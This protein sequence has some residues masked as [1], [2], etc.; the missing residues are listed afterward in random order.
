MDIKNFTEYY[1]TKLETELMV[2]DKKR[3]LIMP[4][5]I[6]LRALLSFFF[7]F[8]L[9]IFTAVVVRLRPDNSD[10]FIVNVLRVFFSILIIG[11]FTLFTVF[12][13]K[14]LIKT[15]PKTFSTKTGE[16][17]LGFGVFFFL[18]GIDF[19]CAFIFTSKVRSM[20]DLNIGGIILY[21][22]V[23]LVGGGFLFYFLFKIEQKFKVEFKK[24]IMAKLIEF[25]LPGSGY[26]PEEAIESN[27]FFES[28]LFP[29]P[30]NLVYKGSDYLKI[31]K[32]GVKMSLS[33]LDVSSRSRG[34]STS[35]SSGNNSTTIFSGI[36]F[37]ILSEKNYFG[38]TRVFFYSKAVIALQK[39][40]SAISGMG[41]G[42]N[43]QRIKTGNAAFDK[44]FLVYSNYPEGTLQCLTSEKMKNILDFYE[45]TK[46]KFSVSFINNIVYVATSKQRNIF[47]PPIFSS[48]TSIKKMQNYCNSIE[49]IYFY[50]HL[51]K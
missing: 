24:K 16:V 36:F 27:I 6:L 8:I 20:D 19:L 51:A 17:M 45:R 35:R 46:I 50:H 21:V 38:D 49:E 37:R 33:Y 28:K 39:I 30:Y 18:I 26:N 13:T 5:A 3:K 42:G 23:S 48:M 10:D 29:I 7:L 15:Y 41:G 2:L 43:S 11:I 22:F 47:D 12:G 32:E 31:S 4:A 9:S 25:I 40:G 14:G 44:L 1:N 34:T